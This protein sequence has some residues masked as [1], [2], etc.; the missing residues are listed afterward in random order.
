[1]APANNCKTVD[2]SRSIGSLT[3]YYLRP[4][5][6]FD[7]TSHIN[8]DPQEFVDETMSLPQFPDA[9]K[10]LHQK[11]QIEK[12]HYTIRDYPQ[13]LFL[14]KCKLLLVVANFPGNLFSRNGLLYS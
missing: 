7:S 4:K 3:S 2:E 9:L 14:G 11:L 13:L 5:K 10:E 8:L 12:S 6:G 1:M